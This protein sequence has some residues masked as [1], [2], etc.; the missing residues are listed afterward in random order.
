MMNDFDITDVE[1]WLVPYLRELGV[2]DNVYTSRPRSLERNIED[3]A[4]VSVTGTLADRAAYGDGYVAMDL[5]SKDVNGRK[6]GDRLSVMYRKLITGFP[7]ESGRYIIGDYPTVQGDAGD[8]F[9][10]H[11]RMLQAKL[12]I[13]IQ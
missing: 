5:F 1:R 13:K 8:D 2:S 10:F 12:I 7:A 6:N 9:G 3:F 11:V 4:I